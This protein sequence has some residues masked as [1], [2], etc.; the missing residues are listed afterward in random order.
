[1]IAD[2]WWGVAFFT[3]QIYFDFSA[4]SDMAIG[5]ARML[6]KLGPGDVVTVTRIDRKRCVSP[7]LLGL[8]RC[9]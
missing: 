3:F 6:G 7:T 8:R 5:I 4:Y 2:A 9:G 1:M